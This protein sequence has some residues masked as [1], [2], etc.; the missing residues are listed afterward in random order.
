MQDVVNDILRS[1]GM[2]RADAAFLLRAGPFILHS[3]TNTKI[4]A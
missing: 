4:S 1:F 3:T 2:L